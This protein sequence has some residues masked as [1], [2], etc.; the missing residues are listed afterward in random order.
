MTNIDVVNARV[1]ERLKNIERNIQEIKIAI[2]A[3]RQEREKK[4]VTCVEWEPYKRII[5]AGIATILLSVLGAV[6]A[7]VIVRQ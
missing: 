6:L 3:E 1:D 5:Q 4:F 2:E 7:L